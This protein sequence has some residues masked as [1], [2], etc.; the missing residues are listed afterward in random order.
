MIV[1]SDYGVVGYFL[2]ISV[3]AW[4]P[5]KAILPISNV[6]TF[7]HVFHDIFYIILLHFFHVSLF[8]ECYTEETHGRTY[9]KLH[10]S[11]GMVLN[12]TIH[13]MQGLHSLEK[14]LNFRGSP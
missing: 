6:L 5:S 4:F 14:S 1:N 11:A 10:D 7:R 3:N 12:T 8:L 9:T 13:H 2:P